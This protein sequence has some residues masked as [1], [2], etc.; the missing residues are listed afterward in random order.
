MN[1]KDIKVLPGIVIDVADPKFIGRVKAD[2]PGLFDSSVMNKEGLPWI[3]PFTMQGY[4]RFSKLRVSSK[5]WIFTNDDYTEFWYM[6]MFQLNDDTK[7]IISGDESDYDESEVLLSRTSGDNSTFIYY[8]PS[9]G[10]VLQNSEN[11]TITLTPDNQIILKS[12]DGQVS[13]KN[14]HVYL[15]DGNTDSME[16][17]VYG[18]KL[19]KLLDELKGKFLQLNAAALAGGYTVSLAQP[20]LECANIFNDTQSLLT[21]NSSVN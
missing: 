8:S 2:C 18:E 4:Q 20:F 15:G 11:T 1:L 21:T 3:Y 6:P 5:I 12:G 16:A 19:V 9:K 14:N 17:A 7:N 13:I 10:I